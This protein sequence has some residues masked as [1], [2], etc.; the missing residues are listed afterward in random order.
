MNRFNLIFFLDFEFL[1]L[2]EIEKS[3]INVDLSEIKC[4]IYIN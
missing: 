1:E 4:K 2:R 3:R